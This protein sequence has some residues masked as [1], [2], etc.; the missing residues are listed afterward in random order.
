MNSHHFA[1]KYLLFTIFEEL[2]EKKKSGFCWFLMLKELQAR[3]L[4]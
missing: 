2:G 4:L 1:Q 3:A